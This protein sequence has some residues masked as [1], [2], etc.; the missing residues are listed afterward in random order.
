MGAQDSAMLYEA[1]RLAHEVNRAYCKEIGDDSQPGWEDAPQ[2]QRESA[3]EGARAHLNA[4]SAGIP[5]SPKDSHASWLS[6]KEKDGWVWG[7]VKDPEK[8]QHPCMVPYEQLPAEQR[9]KDA[10]FTA[11]VRAVL[12]LGDSA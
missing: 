9:M 3:F 6:H 10:L 7:P 11:V 2:W 12:R 1:A 5:M 4:F 8:K